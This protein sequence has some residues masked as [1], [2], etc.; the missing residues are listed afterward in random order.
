MANYINSAVNWIKSHP[1]SA[2][3]NVLFFLILIFSFAVWFPTRYLPFHWD[4]AAF[5]VDAANHFLANGFWPFVAVGSN[6]SHPPLLPAIIALIFKNS[7]QP[8]LWSHVFMFPFLPLLVYSVYVLGTHLHSRTVG[9]LSAIATAFT[10]VILAENAIVYLDLPV[11]SLSIFGLS[12]ASSRK[13]YSAV[14]FIS[15]AALFK[16]T[17]LITLPFLLLHYWYYTP[18]RSAP[19]FLRLSIPLLVYFLWLV[20]HYTVTGWFLAE[21]AAQLETRISATLDTLLLSIRVFATQLF[22]DQNRSVITLLAGISA[23]F[24]YSNNPKLKK[25]PRQFQVLLPMVSVLVTG[26]LLFIISA[27]ILPRYL[28]IMIPLVYIIL[29]VIIVEALELASIRFKT[30]LL[31]IVGVVVTL[32]FIQAWHPRLNLDATYRFTPPADLR[33]ID[34]VRTFQKV[35]AYID[36]NH[37]TTT[38][39]GAFPENFYLQRPNLGYVSNPSV[40]KF[41]QD[42][43]LEASNSG[44]LVVHPYSPN[45]Q[46]CRTLLDT[47]QSSL[48]TRAQENGTWVEVYSISASKS[49]ET[50]IEQ[51]N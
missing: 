8:I 50:F 34:M 21:P 19:D 23:Y 3:D 12:L 6:F 15:L 28:I 13:Y 25:L 30:P 47:Y 5:I 32:F 45:Q 39:F 26:A 43:E 20:Y 40:F 11:A 49:A 44:L 42:F 1:I 27:Q 22:L 2:F 36:I 51:V 35:S 46:I 41:C 4:A 31:L 29:F 33:V 9:L 10:P 24:L 14:I 16:I 38:V 18:R 7:S 48:L 17:A 37:P